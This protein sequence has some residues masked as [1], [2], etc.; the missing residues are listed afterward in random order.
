MAR[1]KQQYNAYMREYMRKKHAARK[2]AAIQL[3]G[4]KCIQCGSMNNL[5]FDHID[6][7][8]KSYTIA[9]IYTHSEVKFQTELAKCQL[10][11]ESCHKEKHASQAPCGTDARY[12]AGCRCADCKKAHN[13]VCKEWKKKN[14]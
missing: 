14:S 13:L 10:L 5:E 4:S 6:P 12:S 2:A 11:C 1:N 3:L 9:R 7:S 8:T